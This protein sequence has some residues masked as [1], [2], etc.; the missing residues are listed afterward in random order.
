ME[1]N[2]TSNINEIKPAKDTLLVLNIHNNTIEMV[3]GIDK[4]GNLQTVPPENKKEN[5]H[6]QWH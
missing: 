5:D 2:Q 4:E 3:K 1:D 6:F